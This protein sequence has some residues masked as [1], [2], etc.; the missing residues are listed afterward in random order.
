MENLQRPSYSMQHSPSSGK[1]R[2]V[3]KQ[4]NRN[5]SFTVTVKLALSMMR[6]AEMPHNMRKI[7]GFLFTPRITLHTMIVILMRAKAAILRCIQYNFK[8]F[9]TTNIGGTLYGR[10]KLFTRYVL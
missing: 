10:S 6:M 9:T 7:R 4:G 1:T 5:D 2:V 8:A 3:L